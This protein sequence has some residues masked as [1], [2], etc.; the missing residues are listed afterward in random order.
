LAGVLAGDKRCFCGCV[1]RRAS[2]GYKVFWVCGFERL[3]SGDVDVLV[4]KRW[5]ASHGVVSGRQNIT[6]DNR[7]T[8]CVSLLS[9]CTLPYVQ[10]PGQPAKI[11]DDHCCNFCILLSHMCAIRSQYMPL[12]CV[13]GT[14]LGPLVNPIKLTSCGGIG[15]CC[16]VFSSCEVM[17]GSMDPGKLRQWCNSAILLHSC[18]CVHGTRCIL[19]LGV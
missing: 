1:W 17:S 3:S 18:Q 19:C 15:V 6:W 14:S 10:H 13:T 2:R 9:P 7:N 5:C 11:V 12:E 8:T 4:C 16:G